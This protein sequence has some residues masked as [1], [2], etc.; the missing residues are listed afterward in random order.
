MNHEIKE[1]EKKLVATVE[2]PKEEWIKQQEK[3]RR[4]IIANLKMPGFRKGKLPA[5]KIKS[6]VTD[7]EV[8]ERASN[9]YIQEAFI[10]V[11]QDPKI[12]DADIVDR[13]HL[14]K[15]M[16][17]ESLK[18]FFEYDKL[19]EVKI[20]NYKN[21]L[22]N[23]KISPKVV[24]DAEVDQYIQYIFSQE[25]KY[26]E[27]DKKTLEKGDLAVF[28]FEG[29]KGDEAFP[30]GKAENYELEIG[31]NRFIPGFEEQ[32]I[33]LNIGE[34]KDIQLKFPADYHEKNLANQDVVFKIKL[35]SIKE[36]Q[37]PDINDEYVKNLKLPNIE[38]LDQLKETS[39]KRMQEEYNKKYEQ[40][41]AQAI[42]EHLEK[43][44]V[45]E[46]PS[47]LIQMEVE[48]L[49]EN[50]NKELKEQKVTLEKYLQE[51]KLSKKDL[52]NNLLT[53]AQRNLKVSLALEKIIEL[54]N[55]SNSPED[56]DNMIKE[57]SETYKM[58]YEELKKQ[59]SDTSMLEA[60]ML[61]K[62]VLEFLKK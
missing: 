24:S 41:S 62:K 53:L 1:V 5:S 30:G 55:I 52:E 39:K 51:N 14:K 10:K 56:I 17:N 18:L 26:V 50:L 38:T 3:T 61:N 43:N 27:S 44:V 12:K 46:L 45:V 11:S 57:L 28:D 23:S 40:E 7:E 19:P 31:S 58:P 54:E 20:E 15:E 60:Q 33:G 37:K 32:M 49:R 29:F 47:T 22:S 42:Y 59:L 48:K 34:N 2:I 8:R 25:F 9:K 35:H 36:I 16:S 13:P 21:I 6:I 4:D